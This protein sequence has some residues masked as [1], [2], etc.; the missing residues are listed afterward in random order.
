MRIPPGYL[1]WAG[2]GAGVLLLGVV[3]ATVVNLAGLLDTDDGESSRTVPATVVTGAPCTANG[4]SETV[5]L[6]VDGRERTARFDG[7]GHREGEP[8]EV[9]VPADPGAELVVRAAQATS[10]SGDLGGLGS[11]LV[12]V[13]GVAGAGYAFLVRRGPRTAQLPA[14]LRLA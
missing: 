6:V 9:S 5:S 12:V 2:V 8:V 3:I 11:V 7:C 4:A 13:S 14:P 1:R 10:G